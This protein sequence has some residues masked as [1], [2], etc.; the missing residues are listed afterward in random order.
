MARQGEEFGIIR[1]RSRRQLFVRKEGFSFGRS[2]VG[3][4][5]I[6][7]VIFFSD[8]VW[9]LFGLGKKEES[10]CRQKIRAETTE[11]TET[12]SNIGLGED[13]GTTHP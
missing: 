12:R 9:W 5:T 6:F 13:L 3:F 2:R 11:N 7:G 4:S 1:C 10:L 8:E